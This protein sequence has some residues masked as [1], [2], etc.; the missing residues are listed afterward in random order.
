MRTSRV[1]VV[2]FTL[3]KQ[4]TLPPS[5]PGQASGPPREYQ[6]TNQC[7]FLQVSLGI[8]ASCEQFAL[9]PEMD[10]VCWSSNPFKMHRVH[11]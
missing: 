10:M 9:S 8:I 6:T 4:G 11:Y 3:C 1:Y 2:I 7:D 5:T